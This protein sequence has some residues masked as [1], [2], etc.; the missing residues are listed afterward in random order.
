MKNE[1][2][3]IIK[4]FNEDQK[5]VLS[6]FVSNI[7]MMLFLDGTENYINNTIEKLKKDDNFTKYFKG[8]ALENLVYMSVII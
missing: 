6:V 2:K 1:I 8:L 3:N 7:K 5:K 4:D